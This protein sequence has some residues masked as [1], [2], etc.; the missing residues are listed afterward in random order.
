MAKKIKKI[1][2]RIEEIEYEKSS[3]NIFKDFGFPNPEEAEAKAELAYLIRSVIKKKKLTQQQAA[4]LMDIDQPKVS[5]ITR[6]I[7]S[8]FTIEWLMNCLIALGFDIEIKA[9]KSKSSNPSIHVASA[10]C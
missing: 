2:G 3:G 10:R 1:K 6:G 4:K 9:I 5:K 8:E 7:L